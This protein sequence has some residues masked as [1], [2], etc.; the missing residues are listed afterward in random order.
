MTELDTNVGFMK[1]NGAIKPW[2]RFELEKLENQWDFYNDKQYVYVKSQENPALLAEL[3]MKI[4]SMKDKLADKE[5]EFELD[6]DDDE[7]DIR[8]LGE[9][10]L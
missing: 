9:D 8:T 2:K 5:D 4:R 3:D 6:E 7:F 10:D 1:V